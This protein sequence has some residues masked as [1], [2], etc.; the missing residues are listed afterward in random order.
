MAEPQHAQRG[1]F[2]QVERIPQHPAR[3]PQPRDDV[4]ITAKNAG[5]VHHAHRLPLK[6]AQQSPAGVD[7]HVRGKLIPPAVRQVVDQRCVAEVIFALPVVPVLFHRIPAI[8]A[9]RH[10]PPAR[11]ADAHHLGGGGP[12]IGHMLDH[13]VV[14]HHTEGV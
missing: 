3:F 1:F 7:P 14:H 13:L 12:I 2:R 11:L 5:V 8:G 4:V 9:E 10:D 6:Q